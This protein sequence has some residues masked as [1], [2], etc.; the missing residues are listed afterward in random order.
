MIKKL[1]KKLQLK[2]IPSTNAPLKVLHVI[3]YLGRGGA[4]KLLVNILPVYKKLGLE[5]TVLQLSEHQAE[6]SHVKALTD[7][8]V[9]CF[10][11]SNASVYSPKHVADLVRF[12][13]NRKFDI[14]HAHL[15]PSLY[16]TALAS[17]FIADNPVLVY[18]EHSTQNKRAGKAYLRPIEKWIYGHY[19]QVVAISSKVR[20]FLDG[21]VCRSE[22]VQII[23]NG[24]DTDAFYK[25]EKYPESFW[26]EEY[27]LP[28]NAFKL[29]MTAR[30]QYPKDHK[31]LIE[32]L[33]YLPANFCLFIA[34]DG[35]DKQAVEEYAHQKGTSDRVFF[36]GFRSDVPRL[37]KSV[38]LNILS[39]AYEG[40]SGVT[41]EGLAAERPFLGSDVPGINDVVPS[42]AMVF[43]A[44][45]ARILSEKVQQ[46]AEM[47]PLE[48][49]ALVK[50]GVDHASRN[51]L[52][53]MA[54][55]HIELYKALLSSH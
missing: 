42:S 29:M 46:I 1:R 23:H 36:L 53:Q 7:Q 33:S 54:K 34:G 31:T 19:D 22:Q 41:L 27:N 51:S 17:K 25:A 39:S 40:M 12:L 48:L 37:M 50:M 9:E 5:I 28:P 38:D 55:N 6:P 10:S 21:R 30:I 24:V 3:N 2:E 43:P 44:G 47:S 32:A 11:L 14:I 13:K 8:G 35:P 45:D 18:T 20:A 26:E 16:W 15:F 4:E 49:S 52:L